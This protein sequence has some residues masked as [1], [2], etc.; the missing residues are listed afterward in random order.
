VLSLVHHITTNTKIFSNRGYFFFD[1]AVTMVVISTQWL[2]WRFTGH[3]FWHS[4]LHLSGLHLSTSTIAK[5]GC[6]IY[7]FFLLL[8]ILYYLL[9]FLLLL[10]FPLILFYI[11][12]YIFVVSY[13]NKAWQNN[14]LS[15]MQA[16][17]YWKMH[18]PTFP[19]K[20]LINCFESIFMPW[21]IGLSDCFYLKLGVHF[22]LYQTLTLVYINN[23]QCVM[24]NIVIAVLTYAR[25]IISR[26]G[27]KKQKKN[28]FII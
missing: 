24:Y 6:H 13:N 10:L 23:V 28:K 26:T 15:N 25:C 11:Y 12:I 8:G 3:I 16:K 1:S 5:R 7:V 2:P 21:D 14:M 4:L 20:E 22:Y 27:R 17:F 9:L 19:I 18:F